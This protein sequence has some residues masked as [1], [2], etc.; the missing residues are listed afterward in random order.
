MEEKKHERHHE[1]LEIYGAAI[2]ELLRELRTDL[3][4]DILLKLERRLEQLKKRYE[5]GG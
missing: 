4:K 3:A 5:T 2:E 1:M